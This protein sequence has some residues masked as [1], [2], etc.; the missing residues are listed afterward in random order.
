MKINYKNLKPYLARMNNPKLH[1]GN[2]DK[3]LFNL[4]KTFPTATLVEEQADVLLIE[5]FPENFE[6]HYS[7]LKDGGMCV[8]FGSNMQS[9]A[10]AILNWRLAKKHS[11]EIHSI[12]EDHI[13]FWWKP[14]F[15]GDV[16]LAQP[17]EKKTER[18][19]TW[20]IISPPTPGSCHLTGE[21]LE[22]YGRGKVFVETGTY[23]GLGVEAA[24]GS[25]KF[26]VIYSVELD[27]D[28]A[29]RAADM[30]KR[31]AII[32]NRDSPEAIVDIAVGEPKGSEPM[33]ATFWLDAH[34]SGP[35]VGGASGGT[36]VLDE[37]KAIK[38]NY[39]PLSTIM[40]DDRRLFGS[41][42]WSG[43]TEQQAMDLIKQINPDYKIEYADGEIEKDIIVAYV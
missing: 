29:E 20:E 21:M 34:A 40:I 4:E 42:E 27:K 9:V 19:K 12:K 2:V 35:L 25:G 43:V 37:L 8:F 3:T 32:Y 18:R 24:L 7:K 39:S 30:F 14:S 23:F 31:K 1:L 13:W 10:G 11:P 36:P 17:M 22:K 38:E 16:G 26:D 5:K 41:G 33:V 28:L 15:R 6:T